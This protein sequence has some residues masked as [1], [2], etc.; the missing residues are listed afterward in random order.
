MNPADWI[1]TTD[2]T[3]ATPRE[4]DEALASL[5]RDRSKALAKLDRV[6]DR[7]HTLIG[8]KRTTRRTWPTTDAQ[9]IEL[10]HTVTLLPYE[11]RDRDRVLQQYADLTAEIARLDTLI[12]TGDAEYDRRGGWMRVYLVDNSNGHVHTTTA[13]RNTYITT[14]FCWITE[15][16]GA[17]PGEVVDRA[18]ERTCL[19]CFPEVRADIL[20]GRV[21][22]IETPERQAARIERERKAAEK[23]RK[24]AEKGITTPEGEPLYA[25]AEYAAGGEIRD[26]DLVK[27]EV[28]ANRRALQAATDLAM[29]R[30]DHPTA[31]A[32]RETL[33][34]C[35]EA[36]A[37]KRGTS[38]THERAL[39]EQKVGKKRRREKW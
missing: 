20:A 9:A 17:T 28:A 3:A 35:V 33:R 1:T 38:A 5:S 13:C 31:D 6:H 2:L 8:E 30:S 23:A 14:R 7:A 15:L 29:Y 37:H 24:A 4:I 21:C 10:L 34:R 27:T 19:T 16:S 32:W 18:G 36:L 22:T 39:I 26:G 25:A 11:E 12:K